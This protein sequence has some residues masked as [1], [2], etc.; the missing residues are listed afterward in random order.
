MQFECP[1]L[2]AMSAEELDEWRN[3]ASLAIQYATQKRIAM[4]NREKGAVRTALAMEKQCEALY[5][6][7]RAAGVE[8]W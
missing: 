3:G 5:D 1:N 6:K 7:M 2:D 8:V 4:S